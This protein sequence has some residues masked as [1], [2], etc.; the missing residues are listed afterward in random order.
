MPTHYTP[1]PSVVY[2]IQDEQGAIKIGRSTNAQDRL[3]ALQTSTASKLSMIGTING[4]AWTEGQLHQYFAG[5]RIRG[6]WFRPVPQLIEYI[7][8]H[9]QIVER[10]KAIA[11]P[12]RVPAP[13]PVATVEYNRLGKILILIGRGIWVIAGAFWHSLLI[14]CLSWIIAFILVPS[15]L[16]PTDRSPLC[17]P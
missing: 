5:A 13:K 12:D 1:D 8:T 9:A 16:P 3:S 14:T 17:N 7:N 6:E 4:G 15:L 2:F 10:P 11:A